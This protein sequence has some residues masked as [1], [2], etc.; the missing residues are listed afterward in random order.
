[1]LYRHRML[2]KKSVDLMQLLHAHPFSLSD[3]IDTSYIDNYH[4][5]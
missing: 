5:N 2:S 1:M 3:W 4:S